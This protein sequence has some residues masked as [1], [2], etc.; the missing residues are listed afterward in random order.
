MKTI[1]TLVV[2][3]VALVACS[4]QPTT[5]VSTTCNID[6][7]KKDITLPVANDFLVG[8]WAFDKVTGS[9]PESIE[10][11]FA[12]ENRKLI[13]TIKAARGTKRPDVA[14]AFNMPGAE[15]SGFDVVVK[16]GTLKPAKYS[17]SV[18]QK[19]PD[20]ISL[21]CSQEHFITIK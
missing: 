13:E 19:L 8:G 4:K 20:N 6:T 16:A 14:K 21:I 17:V 2:T 7:P 9:S 12:S 5:L 15:S 18:V 3:A 10:L 11:Q 1:A